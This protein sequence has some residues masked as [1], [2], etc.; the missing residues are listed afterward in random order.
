V[1]PASSYTA[2][3]G[4]PQLTAVWF[5]RLVSD[6]E[7]RVRL[8]RGEVFVYDRIGA[9]QE[10]AS[11]TR[12]FIES[13]LKPYEPIHIHERLTPGEL[14]PLLGRLKPQFT[15]HPE[16]RKLVC[17]MLEE[18]GP[19]PFDCHMDV[20]KL[21]TAYPSGHLTKGI[22]Y[23]FPGHRDTW[24]G[25]PQAQINWWMPVYPL[26]EDNAM[27]FYP[28]Y[29]S[30]PVANNSEEFNYYR[31]NIERAD[32]AEFVDSDPRIQPAATQLDKSEPRVLLL[33]PVG[34][35]ILFSGAQLHATITNPSSL[36]RYSVDFRTVSRRDIEQ[37]QGAP[38]LDAR[39]SGTAL[40]DFS[41]VHDGAAMPE[42]LARMLDPV[43]PDRKEAAVFDPSRPAVRKS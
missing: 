17:R 11:F 1:S 39:C 20:P 4:K 38:N 19:D 24:Y 40:R 13:G 26:Q 32:V 42:H 8:H 34:G 18:L 7:R 22:A 28:R 37:F 36:S 12:E 9:V 21:R 25:A 33:P 16:A 31:R 5:N 23:A 41:R 3:D 43:G 2:E 15:H 14:A 35:I 29:F 30:A 27:A 10:F 6:D